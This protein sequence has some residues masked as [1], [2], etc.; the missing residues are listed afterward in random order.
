[1]IV[2]VMGPGGAGKTT[3]GRALARA[4][5]ARLV[6]AGGDPAGQPIDAWV[7][8][9]GQRL[10]AAPADPHVVVVWSALRRAHRDLLRRYRPDLRLVYLHPSAATLHRRRA[11]ADAIEADLRRLEAPLPDEGAIDN[12]NEDAVETV[13]AR[14]LS[15]LIRSLQEQC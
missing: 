14:I 15:A 10:R 3:V 4:L 11:D 6:D 9:L 2:L 7:R 13:A 5:P 8:E 12:P 1:M